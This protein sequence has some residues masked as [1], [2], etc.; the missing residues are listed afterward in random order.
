M[1]E[2]GLEP[3]QNHDR[4]GIKR[5]RGVAGGKAGPGREEEETQR[6]LQQAAELAVL[7]AGFAQGVSLDDMLAH[8]PE[9]DGP[10]RIAI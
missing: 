1:T 3:W 2:T 5:Y 4:S 8:D 10:W 7:G 9:E 6:A